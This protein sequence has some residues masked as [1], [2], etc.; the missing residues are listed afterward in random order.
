MTMRV[1]AV[2]T[3]AEIGQL[4]QR[5]LRDATCVVFDVLRATS[6]ILTALFNG[7]TRVY[8]VGTVAEAVTL[9]DMRL[10]A[11]LLGGERG[12][13]RID[14]FDLGNSP[15]EYTPEQV[16]GREIITTTTNGT[17][18]LRAC[19]G[20]RTVL[21]GTLLN[22]RALADHLSADVS[23]AQRIVLICAGTGERFALE[24][25][26]AAGALLTL[27]KARCETAAFTADDASLAMLAVHKRWRHQPL[28]A[29][30]ASENGRRL[31]QLG[32]DGDTEWCAR[33][34]P[35]DLIAVERQGALVGEKV[36][37]ILGL[38]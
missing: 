20:A 15:R 2:L 31:A 33:E 38:G 6:T 21:A 5:D 32:L 18:A 10:P 28:A 3:P 24:D 27:L 13:V 23:T 4:P 34:S 36:P 35:F 14:G 1:E 17:V 30:Q 16:S 37:P 25:G 26:F 29:L 22:L 7:A 11:A 12:G 19:A 8:P 9:R